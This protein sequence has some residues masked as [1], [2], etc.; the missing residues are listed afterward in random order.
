MINVYQYKIYPTPT[1]TLELN[2]WL[3]VGQY[4]YNRQLGERFDW[5]DMN[6]C[7]IN[8]CPLVTSIAALKDKPSRYGQQAQLPSLKKDYQFVKST[9]ELLDFSRVPANTLQG[10]CQQVEDTFNRFIKGDKNG[11]KSGRPRFKSKSRFRTLKFTGTQ[12]GKFISTGY[13]GEFSIVKKLG[14]LKVRMHRP[15]PDGS[16]IKT[17]SLTKKADGWY[18]NVTL[19]DPTIPDLPKEEA[20]WENSIG[21]D[22]V[23][24]DDVYLAVSNGDLVKSAKPFRVDES[25]LAKV[26][27]VKESA[28]K[29]S[30][31]RNK[32]ARKQALIHQKIASQRK[33]HRYDT[34]HRIVNS[35]AKAIF[36]ENLNLKGLTKRNKA[37]SDGEGNYLPNGQSAKSGL[38]KSWSD[39][40][41]GMFF[42]A[43]SAVAGKA[44]VSV[45]K[46][47]PAYTSQV[48]CYRNV[49]TFP[50]TSVRE[51]FDEEL[52][53][54]IDR[55]INAALNIKQRGLQVFPVP[56]KASKQKGVKIVRD[57][58]TTIVTA[59]I[60]VF[61]R[62]NQAHNYSR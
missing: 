16:K 18:L 20:T 6:R 1:Q 33:Q 36:V 48:L 32:L 28:K 14:N 21:I 62:I 55:D 4:W 7:N 12:K 15:I 22:A 51:Y 50:N 56:K 45:I 27:T 25:N 29:G 19:D 53:L 23:L 8:S 46:V 37:K 31:R 61:Q 26:S 60:D 13:Y 9:S 40:A 52:G 10:I 35:G 17:S 54:I 5:W 42:D 47:N 49:V 57:L 2:Y 44:G 3:R 41:F 58:D 11:K 34:A 39:A 24:K 43:L 38:N 59:M 30:R